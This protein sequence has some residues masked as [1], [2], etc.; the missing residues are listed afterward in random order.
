M[1]RAA[2]LGL[3]GL[4]AL[5]AAG[6]GGGGD[7]SPTTTP[8]PAPATEAQTG[9]TVV[10]GDFSYEPSTLTV[11]VGDIVTFVNEGKIAHT[12]A[13]VDAK[14]AIRSAVI[15]P[16]ALA[17]GQRQTVTFTRAGTYDYI[18]TFHPKLMSGKVIVK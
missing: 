6:C 14:G 18:C 15:K 17:T 5:A 3:A 11:R 7:A 16:M 1:R 10:M 9:N 8:Q 13:D 4:V 2:H 12:V